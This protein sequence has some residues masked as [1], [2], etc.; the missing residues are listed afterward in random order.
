MIEFILPPIVA[1]LVD[2]GG[3]YVMGNPGT[4][5]SL[6]RVDFGAKDKA[7][8]RDN[9]KSELTWV[10]EHAVCNGKREEHSRL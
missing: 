2:V 6:K 8:R 9:D 7:G 3:M 10:I 4:N 5:K 1:R